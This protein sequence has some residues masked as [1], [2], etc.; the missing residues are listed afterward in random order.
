MTAWEVLA[1]F[2]AVHDDDGDA[3]EAYLKAIGVRPSAAEQ[4][5]PVIE[6]AIAHQ[7]R[8]DVRTVERAA[9]GSRRRTLGNVVDS[10]G[11][12]KRLLDASFALGDGRFVRW[13]EAT[14]ADHEARVAF[15]EAHVAG[16]RTTIDR[17]LEAVAL[18][19]A[20]GV[21]CLDELTEAAA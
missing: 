15:L 19:H 18:L 14:I 9:F 3:A 6:W 2:A 13:G 1:S 12:R 16:V 10:V 17:H 21:T 5:H 7:R 4:L 8:R 20:H 11:E